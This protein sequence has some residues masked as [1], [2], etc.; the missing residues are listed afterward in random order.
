M[1]KNNIKDTGGLKDT[2]EKTQGD[3]SFVRV[4]ANEKTQGD[5]SFVRVGANGNRARVGLNLLEQVKM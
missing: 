1:R 3:G 5:G 4:G 2:G